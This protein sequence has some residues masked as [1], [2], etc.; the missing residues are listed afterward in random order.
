[1]WIGSVKERGSH[2]ALRSQLSTLGLLS[3]FLKLL[4]DYRATP[5]ATTKGE[6]NYPVVEAFVSNAWSGARRG[7]HRYNAADTAASTAT[8]LLPQAADR[9]S[10]RRSDRWLCEANSVFRLPLQS[11]F[12]DL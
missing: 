6:T 11:P 10:N 9:L 2:G 4:T 5:Q 7:E 8:Q 3:H 1:M 12:E